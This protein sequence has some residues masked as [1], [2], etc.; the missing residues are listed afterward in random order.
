MEGLS[1]FGFP[2]MSI[3]FTGGCSKSDTKYLRNLDCFSFGMTDSHSKTKT[4]ELV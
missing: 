1:S 3:W 2:H 4:K